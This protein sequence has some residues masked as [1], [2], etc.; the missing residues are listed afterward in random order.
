MSRM[1]RNL[2]FGLFLNLAIFAGPNLATLPLTS[3]PLKEEEL[4]SIEL[5][6]TGKSLKLQQFLNLFIYKKYNT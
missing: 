5:R 2:A 3:N 1:L 4:F 6:A